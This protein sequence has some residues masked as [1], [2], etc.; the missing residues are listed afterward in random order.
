MPVM[1]YVHGGRLEFTPVAEER[2]G[3]ILWKNLAA[4][5]NQVRAIRRAAPAHIIRAWSTLEL[6][7]P[8]FGCCVPAGRL[9]IESKRHSPKQLAPVCASLR[10]KTG[11]GWQVVITLNFRLGALG[12]LPTREAS[13]TSGTGGLNGAHDVIVALQWIQKHIHSFGGDRDRVTLIGHSTGGTLACILGAS[14]LAAGLFSV[15]PSPSHPAPRRR[16]LAR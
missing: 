13:N 1:V 3:G 16:L 12:F 10:Q 9:S 7:P 4:S 11:W 14:P 8:L 6:C 15:C 2:A 5:T